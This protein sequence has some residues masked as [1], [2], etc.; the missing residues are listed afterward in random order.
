MVL[1]STLVTRETSRHS[2]WPTTVTE[3][4]PVRMSYRGTGMPASKV[5]WF[6]QEGL[7]FRVPFNVA[8]G[9][10]L[11]TAADFADGAVQGDGDMVA[12]IFNVSF[13][14]TVEKPAACMHVSLLRRSLL[15]KEREFLFAAYSKFKIVS[16]EECTG[17]ALR[18]SW[19]SVE[20]EAAEDNLGDEHVPIVEWL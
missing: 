20:L 9:L 7:T 14:K 5:D 4:E 2:L 1:N 12:V 3:G 11:A 6:R 17:G 19:I 18:G 15:P 16:F 13:A 10:D 8:T